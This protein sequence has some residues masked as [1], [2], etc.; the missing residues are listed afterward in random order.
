[1]DVS[2]QYS[3]TLFDSVLMI[4]KLLGFSRSVAIVFSTIYSHDVPLS[5]DD[6]VCESGLSKSAVS[7][8]LR[9]LTHLNAIQEK[10]I[11][12]ERS[13]HYVGMPDLSSVVIALVMARLHLP[14][15]ELRASLDRLPNVTERSQ[16]M[17]TLLS[18]LE[19]IDS[20]LANSRAESQTQESIS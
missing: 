10:S 2:K 19:N 18:T 14:M 3:E 9:E 13:R 8:A 20:L 11:R 4:S 16:Q 1:M 12:G 5:V 7:L 15:T 6:L 17:W